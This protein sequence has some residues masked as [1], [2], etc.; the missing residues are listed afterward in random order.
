ML[1]TDLQQVYALENLC[2]TTPWSP[3]SFKYEIG[4]KEAIL[5]VAV[6]NSQIIG[7]VC[8][9][10]ILDMTHLL[11]FTVSPGFRRRGIGNMLLKNAIEEL[12]H[13]KPGTKLTL[14]VRRSNIPAIKFYEEFGFKVTGSRKKYYQKPEDDAILMELDI[15]LCF[16]N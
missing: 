7:Y 16:S 10:T 11:N 4:N 9:R 5:K 2:Y 15:S 12:K 3:D 6:F 1:P 14:E 13:L 8:I